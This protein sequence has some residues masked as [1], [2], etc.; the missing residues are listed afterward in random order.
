MDRARRTLIAEIP[1]FPYGET[2]TNAQLMASAPDLLEA[3][4]WALDWMSE[5]EHYISDSDHESYEIL[6]SAIAKARGNN[7][8]NQE[9]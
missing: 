2:E 8:N 6:K 4:E 3:C 5:Y 9:A 7:A 1:G